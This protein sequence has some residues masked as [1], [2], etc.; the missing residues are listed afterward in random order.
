[1]TVQ[2]FDLK[3]R[4]YRHCTDGEFKMD[5]QSAPF[6]DRFD[7]RYICKGYLYFKL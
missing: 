4:P 7:I 6:R 2:I 1:M 5:I 3:K